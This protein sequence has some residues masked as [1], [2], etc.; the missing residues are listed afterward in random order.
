MGEHGRLVAR[1]IELG[2]LAERARRR[3]ISTGLNVIELP[4]L[5]RESVGKAEIFE[6]SRALES[7]LA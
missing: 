4:M 6:L 1:R 2:A 5:F 7:G 3:L